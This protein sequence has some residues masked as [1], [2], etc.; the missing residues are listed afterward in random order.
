MPAN[1]KVLEAMGPDYTNEKFGGQNILKTYDAIC[2]NI[3][4]IV[5]DKY[6]RDCQNMFSKHVR[7]GIKEGLADEQIL[8]NFK[9]EVKDKYPELKG[10]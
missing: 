5:P 2:R 4:E 1:M 7:N 10:L 6:T 3:L 9:K 8:D